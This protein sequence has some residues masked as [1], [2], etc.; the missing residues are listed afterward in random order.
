MH[1]LLL[2]LLILIL[3]VYLVKKFHSVIWVPFRIQLHFKRQGISGPGYRP[4]TGNS[5]EIRSMYVEAQSKPISPVDHDILH[6]AS[7]FY[8]RWSLMYG[9]NFLYWFG[10]IPRL[11]IF[12]PAMIKEVLMNTNGSFEKIGFNPLSKPLFGDGLVML[13]GNRW[14]FHRRIANNAFDMAR[15]KSWVPEIV[16]S[17]RKMLEK[18]EEIRGGRDDFEME[19]HKELHQL[20]ADI[21]SRTAFGSSFEE[22]KRIFVLQE[23]QMHLFTQAARSV[24]FP[25]FRF[26]PTKKNR[27][28]WRLDSETRESIRKLIKNNGEAGQNSRN[29]LSLL[30]SAYKNQDG[31]EERLSEEE[32][33]DECKTFYLG[34]KETTANLLTW[35]LVLLALHQDWQIKVREEV[36]S[37]CGDNGVPV[38][39]N[40]S[41]LKIVNMILN[42]TLR[43]YP[44]AVI[45]MRQTSNKA[46]VKIGSLDVPAGTQLSLALTA[47]HHD[48]DIWG[49]DASKFNPLRFNESRKR[50]ASFFPFGLGQRVCVGQNLATVEAKV[51]LASIIQRYSFTLSP[52]YVHAPML[53]ISLQPQHGAHIIFSR[54]QN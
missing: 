30:M 27:E 13:N 21:I 53:F 11:A 45:L 34:G 24:Y 16:T 26:L 22:G 28:R 39:E 3:L 43:L 50:L 10:S 20:S 47:V 48:T 54:I 35:A 9:K 6:R 29:F 14:A 37:V 32:I 36:F 38:A 31:E 4:I 51:V 18:W 1:L 12:D 52:T 5:A 2:L 8:Y 40:L 49:E 19:V 44:P 17:T 23:Q 46:N 42:E 25:G 15:V 7:P 41:E 33:I